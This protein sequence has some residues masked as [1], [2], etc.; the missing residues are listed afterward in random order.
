MVVVISTV[1]RLK[2][3]GK[4]LLMASPVISLISVT[5]NTKGL[6]SITVGFVITIK[7]IGSMSKIVP[8]LSNPHYLYYLK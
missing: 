4:K 6:P 7:G 5:I 3:I 2:F 8:F 1:S